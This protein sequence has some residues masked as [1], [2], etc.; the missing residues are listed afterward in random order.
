MSDVEQGESSAMSVR[1]S[2]ARA[3]YKDGY[4]SANLSHF[5]T[6]TASAIVFLLQSLYADSVEFADFDERS[7][8]TEYAYYQKGGEQ[9]YITTV[10]YKLKSKAKDFNVTSIDFSLTDFKDVQLTKDRLQGK[11]FTVIGNMIL[12]PFMKRPDKERTTDYIV[13]QLYKLI[14]LDE[15]AVNYLDATF[16]AS[17]GYQ[18]TCAT[19]LYNDVA[20][21]I[22]TI[23]H[24]GKIFDLEGHRLQLFSELESSELH[25]ATDKRLVEDHKRKMMVQFK[26][27]VLEEDFEKVKK[28]VQVA[29]RNAEKSCRSYTGP[30][31]FKKPK[32]LKRHVDINVTLKTKP[33]KFPGGANWTYGFFMFTCATIAKAPAIALKWALK[34]YPKSVLLKAKSS[35]ELKAEKVSFSS[36]NQRSWSR[37][38]TADEDES[39]GKGSKKQKQIL[40]FQTKPKSTQGKGK[41]KQPV[42]PKSKRLVRCDEEDE[43]AQWES[44]FG[45]AAEEGSASAAS[46]SGSSSSSI[47]Q[48]AQEASAQT[49]ILARLADMERQIALTVTQSQCQEIAM[50][51]VAK[52][53]AAFQKIMEQLAADI[54]SLTSKLAEQSQTAVDK[55]LELESG[56]PSEEMLESIR[57]QYVG[58]EL[59]EEQMDKIMFKAVEQFKLAAKAR[60]ADQRE[61]ATNYTAT[62]KT[63]VKCF[64]G[65]DKKVKRLADSVQVPYSTPTPATVSHSRKRR[66]TEG[67]SV[68]TQLQMDADQPPKKKAAHAATFVSPLPATPTVPGSDAAAQAAL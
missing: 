6:G 41:K 5:A 34:G 8:D 44:D 12:D 7:G 3:F 57:M 2:R 35:A 67:A 16:A 63:I 46:S 42:K 30:S 58:M 54:S 11:A 24:D 26:E 60:A 59:S 38:L 19:I 1:S 52:G 22:E 17:R 15:E 25:E 4:T 29:A 51:E 27:E 14:T 68:A 48:P 64:T 21:Q 53:F 37:H 55:A 36:Q 18:L 49:Q 31:N 23:F 56:A 66:L 39:N 28:A 13:E 32:K 61:F 62:A 10:Y 45:L 50:S 33:S 40:Q 65:V 43:N 9:L 47:F 20:E